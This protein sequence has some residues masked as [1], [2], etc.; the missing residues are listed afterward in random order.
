MSYHSKKKYTFTTVEH[1]LNKLNG[2]RTMGSLLKVVNELSQM[3]NIL[4]EKMP[5]LSG[6]FHCGAVD[7]LNDTLILY[8]NN[9]AVHHRVNSQIRSIE[10]VLNDA[11]Y[12]FNKFLVKTKPTTAVS[13]PQKRIIS[14]EQHQMLAEFAQA[15]NRPELI[16]PVSNDIEVVDLEPWEIKL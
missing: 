8:V 3:T 6:V 13:K 9:N 5:D 7:Y 12:L 2:D 1:Q 15:I 11:G 14:P 10:E 4:Y 16:K